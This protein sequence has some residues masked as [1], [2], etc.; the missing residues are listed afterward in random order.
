M[1]QGFGGIFYL[2]F[3]FWRENAK[4]KTT[5]LFLARRRR[6]AKVLQDTELLQQFYIIID[7]WR[8]GAVF[9]DPA[10]H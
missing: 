2:L 5:L 10:Q 3:R 6:K 9:L 1:N 7:H 4:T 8:I